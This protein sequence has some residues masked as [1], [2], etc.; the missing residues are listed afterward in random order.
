[1]QSE[2]SAKTLLKKKKE[3]MSNNIKHFMDDVENVDVFEAI[4]NSPEI[5]QLYKRGL[6]IFNNMQKTPKIRAKRRTRAQIEEEEKKMAEISAKY[7]NIFKN[8]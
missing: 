3:T 1:M 4:E 8:M 7:C 2:K 5:Q 6:D